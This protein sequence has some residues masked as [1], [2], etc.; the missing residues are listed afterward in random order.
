MLWSLEDGSGA[1]IS[2]WTGH[3]GPLA[4]A[5]FLDDA[6]AVVTAGVDPGVRAWDARSGERIGGSLDVPDG[7]AAVDVARGGSSVAVLD[8]A[9]AV[10]VWHPLEAPQRVELVHGPDPAS[11]ATC[12][13]WLQD[14]RRLAIG[15]ADGTLWIRG[16]GADGS[17]SFARGAQDGAIVALAVHPARDELA[18]ACADKRVRFWR[19]GEVDESRPET[20]TF[21]LRSIAWDPRGERVLALGR[22]GGNAARVI[23]LEHHVM[24]R[25]RNAHTGDITCAAFSPD[26]ALALTGASDGSLFVWSTK[27]GEPVVQREDL[28]APVRCAQFVARAEGL[29]VVAGL[30]DGRVCVWPVDPLEAARRR[31]PRQLLSWERDRE[32]ALAAPLPYE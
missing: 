14:G 24:V 17:R 1:P 8:K 13:R 6:R 23:E 3:G 10:R 26:G 7:V 15:C 32:R 28:G 27:D 2:R 5:R 11:R 31:M 9:G 20:F 25:P 30:A 16:D 21:D 22:T 18:I 12:A 19:T 29:S 4:S